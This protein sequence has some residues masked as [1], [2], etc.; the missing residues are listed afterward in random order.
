MKRL[1][2]LLLQLTAFVA[3]SAQVKND[4]TTPLHALQPDYP[5]AY[6]VPDTAEIRQT[7]DRIF[8]YLDAVTPAVLEDGK[9]GRPVVNRQQVNADSRIRPGDFRL[10]SYEWGV[11]YSA[12]LSAAD[13]LK[14]DRY[15]GYVKSR[16]E[17]LTEWTPVFREL[18]KKG[19]FGSSRTYPFHQPAEPHALDDAG[20]IAAAMI[21]AK[22]KGISSRLDEQ[23]GVYI[24]YILTKEYRLPDRTI[25]RN[26]PHKNTLWL[27]DLY[28]ALPA[29]V[30]MGKL[31]GD[32]KF[33]DEVVFQLEAYHKRMFVKEKGLFM[34]G[35]VESME[36]HPAYHWGRANG[37][38]LLTL[39]EV[40]DALPAD[41]PGRTSVL[42]MYRT[43]V[44][45]LLRYQDGTGFW[46]QLLDRPDSYLETSCTA[47]YAYAIARGCNEGWLDP[48]AHAPVAALAWS[49]VRT[50]ISAKG[51]VEGTCVGTGMAFDPAFYYHR[52][53]NVFAAHGY[54]PVLL[55]GSEMYRLAAGGGF[56]MNDS[57]LQFYK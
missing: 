55:A 53:V 7:L 25:A 2:F 51:Q 9:S 22:R 46:H 45:G 42:N 48:R 36:P 34:H 33:Y 4:V 47:I 24:D 29:L 28:M 43:H 5:V 1:L 11:V 23:I 20:A 27:D 39:T 50:K 10:T 8:R 38:A 35:W 52:P 44:Q 30:Q 49:A 3:V 56:A 54:G 15:K 16:M 18:A 17:F 14:E 19:T 32:K 12:L 37:W 40:L 41:Y 6:G 31:T 57:G 26:R 13:I 21:K